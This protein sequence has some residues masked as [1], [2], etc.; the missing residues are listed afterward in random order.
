MSVRTLCIRWREQDIG[1][2]VVMDKGKL[3]GML[4][5]RELIKVLDRARRR[6]EVA[7][8]RC[9]HGGQSADR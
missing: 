1:S 5:F 3:V 8:G 2:L 9:N 4:T 7:G 6:A